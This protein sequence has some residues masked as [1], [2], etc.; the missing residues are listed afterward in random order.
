MHERQNRLLVT[1]IAAIILAVGFGCSQPEDVI[2]P[3]S[4]TK[5]V[6]DPEV[7]PSLPAGY[8]YELW[9][10]DTLFE[11]YTLGKFIWNQYECSQEHTD[12]Q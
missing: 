2:A 6:M 8:V 7:L 3:V 11:P 5:I 12:N 1:L 4:T 10:V 9:V